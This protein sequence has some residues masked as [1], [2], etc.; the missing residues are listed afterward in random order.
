LARTGPGRL[1]LQG[2]EVDPPVL[3]VVTLLV[4]TQAVA[5]RSARGRK[6]T[7]L[8]TSRTDSDERKVLVSGS[9]GS[10]GGYL[11]EDLLGRGY[12][13]IGIDN[14]SKYGRV[15]KP[16]DDHPGYTLVEGDC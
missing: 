14:H 12:T 7:A 6:G 15:E 11:V 4:R 8:V 10:I 3:E 5:R 9:S 16:Y 2:G 1:Q 13:V